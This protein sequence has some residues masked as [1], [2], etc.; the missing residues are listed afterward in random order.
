MAKG[1][2]RSLPNVRNLVTS[3][4]FR[5]RHTLLSPV[6]HAIKDI[7]L[8]KKEH[9]AL[10]H[11]LWPRMQGKVRAVDIKASEGEFLST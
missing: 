10:L 6:N 1:T 8:G 7:G 9:R 3:N 2:P 4:L 11:N 5:A